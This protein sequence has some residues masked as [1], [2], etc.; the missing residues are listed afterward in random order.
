MN[1]SELIGWDRLRHGGL[2]LDAPR[3]RRIAA[4]EP[5]PLSS[6]QERELRRQAGALLDG[7]TNTADF[8]HLVLEEICG[9][10][11]A[12]ASWQR[13]TQVGAEW[14]RRA[15]TGETIK[16]RHL[17]R[18]A[19]GACLPVFIDEETRF[20]IGRGRRSLSQ[21][22]QWLRGGNER[23]AVLTN[24]RQWRL[25]FAGLDFDAW[26]EWDVGTLVRGRRPLRPGNRPADTP[27]PGPL[28]AE[29]QGRPAPAP[30]G[31]PGESQGA[32]GTLG[33]LGRAGPRGRRD[34]R[35]GPR[36]QS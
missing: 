5:P 13:G 32:G 28:D 12:N 15:V 4:H 19:A 17:W 29:G 1:G 26:C 16:P 8:V 23:L 30:G 31:D 2:L 24:G 34:P 11:T 25:I 7:G 27:C 20:G 18:T 35:P 3:L 6:Y 33:R 14:G 21:V 9:F 36:R 22:V 10:T